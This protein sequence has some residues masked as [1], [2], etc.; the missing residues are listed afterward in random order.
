M[1]R[2]YFNAT[3]GHQPDAASISDA[4]TSMPAIF[5]AGQDDAAVSRDAIREDFG[6]FRR[7]AMSQPCYRNFLRR[8][9]C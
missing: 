7:C 9:F 6:H 4:V 3:Q 2:L 1:T 8:Y 5:S